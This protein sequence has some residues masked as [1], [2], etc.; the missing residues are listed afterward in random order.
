[1]VDRCGGM[2]KSPAGRGC[3]TTRVK[4]EIDNVTVRKLPPK[5]PSGK[6][7]SCADRTFAAPGQSALAP[8]LQVLFHKAPP[9]PRR[10]TPRLD[11]L[12]LAAAKM[13]LS[14][15]QN[16]SRSRCLFVFT[17]STLNERKINPKPAS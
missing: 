3:D 1:M 6:Y 5:F 12:L 4:A 13:V 17:S 14:L 10:A 15:Y 2:F 8:N 16:L 7:C 11:E 9:L